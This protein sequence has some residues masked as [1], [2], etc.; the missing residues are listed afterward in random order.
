M[1]FCI[2]LFFFGKSV[3]DEVKWIANERQPK[4]EESEITCFSIIR[5]N[6]SVV[7]VRSVVVAFTLESNFLSLYNVRQIFLNLALMFEMTSLTNNVKL[8]CAFSG[9]LFLYL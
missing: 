1:F 9:K 4:N 7:L 8:A 3:C 2:D 5:L 6:V